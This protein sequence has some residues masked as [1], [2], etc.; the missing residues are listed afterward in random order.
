MPAYKKFSY[1]YE[2]YLREIYYDKEQSDEHDVLEL[3]AKLQGFA[4]T[5]F[6]ALPL[7]FII[8]YRKREYILYSDAVR[9][10]AGYHPRD[11]L[12]S[13]LE[14][15]LYVYQK[16]D[17][18]IYNEKI[19][20]RNCEFLRSIPQS[21]HENYL[22]SYT[23]RISDAKGKHQQIWQRGSYITSPETGL[24]LYSLGICLNLTAVKTDTR[25]VH[26]I[27]K[28][29]RN[30]PANLMM[31]TNYFFP[32]EEDKLFSKREKEVLLYM[33]DGLSTKQIA[34]KMRVADTTVI[35]YRKKMMEKSNTKNTAA[36][37][38]Y[39]TQN[40]II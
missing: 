14:M 16:D 22:F 7:L 25:M 15:L 38:A 28:M 2:G 4:N 34:D 18:K 10:I 6:G 29:N 9:Q 35:T 20:S 26:T 21:E 24:P 23:F 37:I 5:G 40:R 32:N 3:F 33:A 27:E 39:S 12:D 17:F 36:L 30:S 8:D 1:S 13:G 19:F 31:E 11:F